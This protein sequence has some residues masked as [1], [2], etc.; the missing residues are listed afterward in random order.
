MSYPATVLKVMLA[1]PSDVTD[2]HKIA[3]NIISEWNVIHAED[4]KTVLMP[5]EWE[6]HASPEMGERPQAVINKQV[7]KDCD[8]LVAIFWTRIGTP[9][10]SAPSGTV[11]EIEEHIAA[12]KLALI[13]FSSAPV[14]PDSIDSE[15]YTA[16]RKFKESCRK[17]GVV[18][19]YKNPQ[20]FQEKFSRQLAQTVIR[21]FI[22]EVVDKAD[23]EL[24]QPKALAVSEAAREL[25]L[26]AAKDPNG[27]IMRVDT[28]TGTLV[29]T[30]GREFVVRGDPRSEAK[31][32]GAV[33]ELQLGGFIEDRGG[34][35]EVFF[36]TGTG[37]GVA[38]AAGGG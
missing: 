25:L 34:K 20:E 4:R 38:D 37:Y 32:R 6:T 16:L 11:E 7:L 36:V 26:E 12:G 24:P 23:V 3:R 8:V 30:N 19:E 33:D 2:E 18:E 10:G 21:S 28:L 17:R 9:T 13:Y 5:V 1:S 27:L 22:S 31:W 15:Q 35:G 29:Q 14:P